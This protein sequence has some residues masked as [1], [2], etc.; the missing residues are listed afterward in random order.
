M[1]L[2]RVKMS[3]IQSFDLPRSRIRRKIRAINLKRRIP[4][5]M[6]NLNV[7]NEWRD[8]DG[9]FNLPRLNHVP[10]V[11]TY[12]LS[13]HSWRIHGLSNSVQST[14]YRSPT[15]VSQNNITDELQD[16]D[17]SCFRTSIRGRSFES[18]WIMHAETEDFGAEI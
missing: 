12:N 11:Y 6:L 10:F 18:T 1:T 7:G 13:G 4:E 3:L 5:S 2:Y 14:R 8:V 9:L 16:A 17:W 15:K